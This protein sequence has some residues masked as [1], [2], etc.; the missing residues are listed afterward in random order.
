MDEIDITILNELKA[1]AERLLRKSAK[2]YIFRYQLQRSES[3]KLDQSEI[4][5]QYTF[6]SIGKKTGQKL[7]HSF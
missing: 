6:V 3:V 7:L 2:K 1:N 5:Q 4:I